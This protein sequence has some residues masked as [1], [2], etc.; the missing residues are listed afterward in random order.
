MVLSHA[1]QF[2]PWRGVAGNEITQP[3]H[4]S[5]V[6]SIS[7]AMHTGGVAPST[8]QFLVR[9]WLGH[10]FVSLLV[11]IRA[12]LALDLAKGGSRFAP[13]IISHTPDLAVFGLA[14]QPERARV[15]APAPRVP[16]EYP[17]RLKVGI[18]CS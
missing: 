12:V 18:S 3:Q 13:D 10:W 14:S 9:K 17:V 6:L 15:P 2:V 4:A 7:G 16:Y 1:A 8:V 5:N 11:V